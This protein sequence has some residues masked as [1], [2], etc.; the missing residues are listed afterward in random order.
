MSSYSSCTQE[1]PMTT[2]LSR[3]FPTYDNVTHK[4]YARILDMHLVS[5][6]LSAIGATA[7]I[8]VLWVSL[9]I[10]SWPLVPL[11]VLPA[12]V[13]LYFVYRSVLISAHMKRLHRDAMLLYEK[14]MAKR[15]PGTSVEIAELLR[16][17]EHE[18][19]GVRGA[20]LR[21]CRDNHAGGYRT[22]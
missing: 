19:P 16:K 13:T 17:V 14:H 10:R 12:M 6:S 4:S 22:H 18:P 7:T 20:F 1:K 21:Y 3:L 15:E 9:M 2:V 5:V 11:S 8:M